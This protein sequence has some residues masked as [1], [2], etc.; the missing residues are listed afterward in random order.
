V[1]Q[2]WVAVRTASRSERICGE[3]T[4]G[5]MPQME[6][7]ACSNFGTILLPP[8]MTA[9]IQ[10]VVSA[11]ILSPLK[12]KVLDRLQNLVQA[13]KPRSWFTIYLCIFLLLHSC[14]LLTDADSKKA[15]KQG[16]QVCVLPL[17]Y[18]SANH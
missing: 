7:R 16:M 12:Q 3:E 14:A 5:M 1:L 17:N 10:I 15:K 8:V 11:R 6:D 9:Q 4:L 18:E 2:L 13:N